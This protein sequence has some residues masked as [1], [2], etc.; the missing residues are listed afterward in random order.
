[1]EETFLKPFQVS[2]LGR[3]WLGPEPGGFTTR[4]HCSLQDGRGWGCLETGSAAQRKGFVL[5]CSQRGFQMHPASL[6]EPLPSRELCPGLRGL[7]SSRVCSRFVTPGALPG[8]CS[9]GFEP[10]CL[11]NPCSC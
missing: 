5:P 8:L 10:A 4:C 1:M 11:G 3:R 9:A 6:S 7:E 2:P